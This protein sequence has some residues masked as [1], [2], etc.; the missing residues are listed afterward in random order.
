MEQNLSLTPFGNQLVLVNKT[1]SEGSK[2]LAVTKI[3]VEN[4]SF[5]TKL[6]QPKDLEYIS[7]KLILN[8]HDIILQSQVKE[9]FSK[10]KNAEFFTYF[11]KLDS[12]LEV[13][14]DLYLNS[15]KVKRVILIESVYTLNNQF[16]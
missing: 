3:D 16:V 11:L 1:I 15:D 14:N 5:F 9:L 8:E 12:N 10:N 4:K 13:K 2:M 6:F 7:H